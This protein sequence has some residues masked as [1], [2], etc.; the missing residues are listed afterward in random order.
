MFH[1]YRRAPQGRGDPGDDLS[2]LRDE[3]GLTA[4]LASL[5]RHVAA[6]MA[7]QVRRDQVVVLRDGAEVVPGE[8]A[9]IDY[10]LLGSW[11]D[12]VTGKR[13]RVWAFAMVLAASRHVFVRPVLRMDQRAWTEAHVQAFTF[14]GGVPRRLAGRPLRRPGRP[15]PGPQTPRQGPHRTADALHP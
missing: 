13:R 4:S 15:G 8:E 2:T 10:G 9:Q 12:P 14:F 11:T 6:N 3:H 1:E 7:E 5:K